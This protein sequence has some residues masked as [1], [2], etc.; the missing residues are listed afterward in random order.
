M[1]CPFSMTG[2]AGGSLATAC[3]TELLS[4]PLPPPLL[5][6]PPPP[7]LC[8]CAGLG[9]GCGE[10]VG[11]GM[12]PGV[13]RSGAT[14]TSMWM[15]LADDDVVATAPWPADAAG[16][17]VVVALAAADG[18]KPGGG[19]ISRPL[20][21][22][23]RSELRSAGAVLVPVLVPVLALVLAPVLTMV[24]VDVLVADA[25]ETGARC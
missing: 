21:R 17:A 8:R 23:S 14:C 1:T 15:C 24:G 16:E 19:R 20:A 22:R 10:R 3:A 6:P 12:L 9:Q 5:P 4:A 7:L 25:V 13:R 18:T 11:P 2:G